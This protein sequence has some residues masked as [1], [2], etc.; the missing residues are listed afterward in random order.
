[1]EFPELFRNSLY[2]YEAQWSFSEVLFT[3]RLQ[4]LLQQ[5]MNFY[6]FY[7]L[8]EKIF[9]VKVYLT[10][11]NCFRN[12]Y[13]KWSAKKTLNVYEIQNANG[14]FR[15]YVKSPTILRNYL[16]LYEVLWSFNEAFLDLYEVPRILQ[17]F[18]E[19]LRSFLKLY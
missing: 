12:I 2:F 11:T 10:S 14:I 18:S 3:K 8:L 7:R 15:S 1:M 19:C 9:E 5:F 13:K 16:K 6:V 17:K 4:S